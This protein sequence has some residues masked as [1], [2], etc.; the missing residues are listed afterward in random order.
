MAWQG[1]GEV[2]DR[3]PSWAHNRYAKP[4]F[5][6][7]ITLI[8][9]QAPRGGPLHDDQSLRKFDPRDGLRGL[10]S[11]TLRDVSLLLL[12]ADGSCYALGPRFDALP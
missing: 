12:N 9:G 5:K 1:P 11:A 4:G 2:K 7:P 8:L 6:E 10:A 3:A